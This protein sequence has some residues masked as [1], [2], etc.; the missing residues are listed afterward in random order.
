[1]H[2]TQQINQIGK[3]IITG[4]GWD[5]KL[6]QSSDLGKNLLLLVHLS[7]KESGFSNLFS[8]SLL[9]L[10]DLFLELVYPW[11]PNRSNASLFSSQ[12]G[13]SCFT[14]FL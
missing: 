9:K 1:M 2:S 7:T 10:I 5:L 13:L 4:L 12:G 6:L 11:S 8:I 3:E 14:F